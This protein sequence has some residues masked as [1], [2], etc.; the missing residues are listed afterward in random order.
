M[1]RGKN[2]ADR[3]LRQGKSRQCQHPHGAAESSP[4]PTPPSGLE[5]KRAKWVRNQW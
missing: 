4:Q 2:T 3:Q 5:S 1:R